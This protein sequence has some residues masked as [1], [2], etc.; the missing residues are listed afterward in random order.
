ML[1]HAV[2]RRHSQ[3]WQPAPEVVT[4]LAPMPHAFETVVLSSYEGSP[5]T[6]D[7]VK[8][9]CIYVYIYMVGK[10]NGEFLDRSYVRSRCGEPYLG[11]LWVSVCCQMMSSKAPKMQ[12]FEGDTPDSVSDSRF[13]D[14]RWVAWQSHCDL[15]V[16]VAGRDLGGSRKKT[17]PRLFHE[18]R[19]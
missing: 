18:S 1:H 9:I 14:A 3:A 2:L 6:W 15:I 4:A 19:Q 12:T 10:H 7:E 11:Y 17:R 8:S 5:G 16:L 13:G